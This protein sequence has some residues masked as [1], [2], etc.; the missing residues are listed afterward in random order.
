MHFV[1]LPV[2]L[3]LAQLWPD[4]TVSQQAYKLAAALA[5]GIHLIVIACCQ[6]LFHGQEEEQTQACHV[7]SAPCTADHLLQLLPGLCF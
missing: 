7:Q 3:L 4:C 2:Q 1:V 5:D 6:H